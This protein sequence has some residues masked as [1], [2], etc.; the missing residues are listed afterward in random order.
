MGQQSSMNRDT[1]AL[2][3]ATSAPTNPNAK[4]SSEPNPSDGSLEGL[5]DLY[6]GPS[7]DFQMDVLH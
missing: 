2:N 4:R 6:A 1:G 3:L 7:A 5:M